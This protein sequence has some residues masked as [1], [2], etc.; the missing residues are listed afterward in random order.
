MTPNGRGGPAR[1]KTGSPLWR[2]RCTMPAVVAVGT[3]AH[4]PRQRWYHPSAGIRQ[5]LMASDGRPPREPHEI[6]AK[7]SYDVL[8]D[9]RGLICPMPLIKTRQALMV[10]EPGATVCVLATDPD[11]VADFASFCE[12]T[13]HKL[14]SSEHKDA[15]YLYVIEKV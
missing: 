8:L 15:I 6:M 7:Q 5:C 1:A 10:I 13:G 11:T 12:A 9:A 4:V 2:L 3:L 14:L